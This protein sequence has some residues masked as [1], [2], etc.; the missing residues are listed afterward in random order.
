MASVQEERN[1]GLVNE[2]KLFIEQLWSV[3]NDFCLF[4][5]PA[6]LYLVPACIGVPLFVALVRGEL[7]EMFR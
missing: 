1:G 2:I 3:L 6:L 7:K 5:Q 4:L